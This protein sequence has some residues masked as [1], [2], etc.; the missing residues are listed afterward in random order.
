MAFDDGSVHQALACTA[1][2][3]WSAPGA[4]YRPLSANPS[5]APDRL[6]AHSSPPPNGR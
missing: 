1:L 6:L 2:E 3:E 4:L 5:D